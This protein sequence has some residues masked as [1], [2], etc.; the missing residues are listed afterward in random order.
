MITASRPLPFEKVKTIITFETPSGTEWQSTSNPAK[1]TP[2]L[3]IEISE[4]DLHAKIKGMESYLYEKRLWPHPRSPEAL[5]TLANN[6]GSSVGFNLAER[7]NI[8]RLI[9]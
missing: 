3:F 4:L 7:F 2:N 9:T 8:I 5:T 1:F 6:T